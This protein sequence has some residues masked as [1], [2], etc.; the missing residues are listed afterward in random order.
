[1]IRHHDLMGTPT[2]LRLVLRRDRVRFPIWVVGIVGA[3]AGSASSVQ[4]VYA[5]AT[6]RA[7]YAETIGN[8]AGSI[9]LAGPAVGLESMGGLTVFETSL[10]ALVAT[11][12]MAIFLT[13]R[14]T[15]GEEEA[16]RAELL[17]SAEVG[18][19]AAPVASLAYVGAASLLVG[20]GVA[21]SFI[22]LG[23]PANGSWLY[24]A[25]ITATG[26]VFAT[27]ALTAAQLTEHARAAVG[28][29]AAVLAVA[30]ALRAIGDVSTPWLSW[31]SPVG[32][33]QAT[34]PYAGDRW[35]PLL[36][37]LAA[38]GVLVIAAA[39]L[40]ARRDLGAGLVAPRLGAATAAPRLA[41]AWGLSARLQRTSFVSWTVGM[42]LGGVALGSV[43]GDV[44]GLVDDRPDLRD[45]IAP[46]GGDITAA[47]VATAGLILALV[48]AGYTVSSILRMRGEETSGRLEALLATG[49]ARV[50]WANGCIAFS[51]VTSAVVLLAGGVGL[52][53]ASAVGVD[54]ASLI[55]DAVGGAAAYIPAALVVAAVTVALVGWAPR[56]IGIAWALVAGCFTVGYLGQLLTFP[57]WLRDLS[58]YTHVPQVGVETV[59]NGALVALTAVAAVLTAVG[60]AGVRRRDIG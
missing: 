37:S 32:W 22:G 52:G 42:L 26:V 12:L 7:Q 27:V 39:A 23:L 17:R 4:N 58:P 33:S 35:W 49:L 15:R 9:A 57:D 30:F 21:L 18:R 51:V 6:E 43:T 29:S 46:D 56:A 1:M 2:M 34:H 44:A 38:S 13:V 53:V 60:V 55:G 45:A 10:T 47:Y 24:G 54:D 48:A 3:V 36:I 31:L 5:T 59:G 41:G 14:H 40:V 25:S 16:G 8:S 11:A 19:L 20:L 28:G 50:R